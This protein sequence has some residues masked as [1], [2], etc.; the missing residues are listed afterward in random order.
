MTA[1]PT[2]LCYMTIAQAAPLLRDGQLSPVELTRAFLE[3][4]EA[5]DGRLNS[6][7]T[8]LPERA[9]AQ[10]RAAEAEILRGDY[11]GPLHGIPIGLKDL[12]DTAGI[13]TTAMSR[14]TPD[15]VPTEDATTV[16]RLNQAG[17]ILLGKLAMHEFALGGPDFTSLFPP[18]RNPWNLAHIPGGSSSGSGAAVAAGLCM[19]ALGS[20]TGGSIRGPASMCGIVGIKPT[21]GRVS[22]FGVVPLS[23]SQDHC[24]PMT[25]TVADNALM[26]QSLA[27]HDPK[28]PT[29]STAPVPDYSAALRD[30]IAG[31]TIGVPRRYFF[32]AGPDVEPETLAAI[33]GALE[34]M[35]ELGATVRDVDLPHVEQ[36]RAANQTIMMGEAFAYHEH[37]LKTR[38]QDYGAMV[39]DRFLLGGMLTIS[40]YVQAQRVRSLIKREMADAL[41][42]VDV[43]VTPTSPKPAAALEG[44]SGG[45]TLTGPSF[46][47]PFNASGIPAISTPGGFSSDGLPIGLQIAGKPFDEATVLRVAYAYE[48]AAR[49]FERRPE[50]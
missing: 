28:D 27:G 34:V 48:Q 20:D 39:R 43:L 31:M 47:G 9:L 16:A 35:A 18:A 50:V 11:R 8:L 49:W 46:T 4:I 41:R 32:E 37:N 26:L 7:V 24:G 10:A 29:T 13:L 45:A 12:Y 15:R 33:E 36:S 30:G 25:W 38:R 17:T 6:Y 5:I 21:Y 44:Y 42:E 23:W 3:R 22:N 2:E 1:T 40:D 19:G 14:V